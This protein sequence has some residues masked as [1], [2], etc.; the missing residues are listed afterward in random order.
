MRV[1]VCCNGVIVPHCKRTL[2]EIRQLLKVDTIDTVDL[3]KHGLVMIVD[4]EGAIREPPSR[5]NLDATALYHSVYRPGTT[6]P[7][8][9]DVFIC[10]DED[11]A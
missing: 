6:W 7:I 1:L 4:D 2:A 3:H 8:R 9:G 5:I 10:P 11:F